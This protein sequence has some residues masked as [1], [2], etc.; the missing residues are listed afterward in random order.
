MAGVA[1]AVGACSDDV[2][3]L[4]QLARKRKHEASAV[5]YTCIAPQDLHCCGPRASRQS[6]GMRTDRHVTQPLSR[7]SCGQSASPCPALHLLFKLR[8][9]PATRVTTC[10]ATPSIL[11]AAAGALAHSPWCCGSRWCADAPSPLLPMQTY[12][13]HAFHTCPALQRRVCV[14]FSTR[15][16]GGLTCSG[17]SAYTMVSWQS[18]MCS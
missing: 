14:C 5:V 4:I 15:C 11:H 12:Q 9:C 3:C 18:V 10:A 1:G 17:A 7:R 6:M 2:L 13:P 16:A 8:H